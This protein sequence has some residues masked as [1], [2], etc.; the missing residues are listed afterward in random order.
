MNILIVDDDV[1]SAEVIQKQIEA[2]GHDAKIAYTGQ[3]ALKIMKENVFDLILLD[4][5]LP[6][7]MGHE[8][9]PQFKEMQPDIGIVTITGFNT[10]ELELEVRQKGIIFYMVKPFNLDEMKEILNH[11][12]KKKKKST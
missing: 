4:I 12:Q 9:I 2:L 7:C 5:Y 6:D 1:S 8:L 11:F 10:R 3:D